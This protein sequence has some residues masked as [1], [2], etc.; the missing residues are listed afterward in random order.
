MSN[1]GTKPIPSQL[2]GG[3]WYQA[4][5]TS[6]G[7]EDAEVCCVQEARPV[8]PG[9]KGGAARLWLRVCQD[10]ADTTPR[11]HGL[12]HWGLQVQVRPRIM[13]DTGEPGQCPRKDTGF[14]QEN[15]EPASA[16]RGCPIH[17]GEALARAPPA[18]SGSAEDGGRAEDGGGRGPSPR[19]QGGKARLSRHRPSL[20]GWALHSTFSHPSASWLQVPVSDPSVLLGTTD[21]RLLML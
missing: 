17:L 5:G 18:P 10:P 16:P 3:G 9:P 12:G 6:A 2:K 20:G 4:G 8:L 19:A 11:K 15:L 1:T 7:S 13:L 21:G 14:W